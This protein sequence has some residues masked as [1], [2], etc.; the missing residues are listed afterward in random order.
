M[1]TFMSQVHRPIIVDWAQ[2]HPLPPVAIVSDFFL[3][4]THQ[5]DSQLRIPRLVFSPSAAFAMSIAFTL[6]RDLPQV[7]DPENPN[8]LIS[9]PKIPTSPIYPWWQISH[10]YRENKRGDPDW[11]FHRQ[12]TLF[13]F[14]SWG[15]AFN[16]F[17]ELEPAYLDH[18][19]KDVG[20]DRVW[21]VGPL[22]PPKDDFTV[23][24]ADRGGSSSVPCHQL[25]TWLDSRT[26]SS[27]LYVCFGSRTFLTSKQVE[28]LTSALELSGI[29]FILSVR[30]PDEKKGGRDC[31]MIPDDFED[32]VAGRG[33]VIKGWAP[34]LAI[35]GHPAVGAFLTHCG[36][37]SVLEGLAAGV[38][39]GTW[40]MGSDQFTNAK[41]LVDQLGVAIRVAEGT[42]NVPEA[43]EM[44]R[45]IESSLD[46]ARPERIRAKELMDAALGAISQR[47][48]SENQMEAL[49]NRLSQ[50]K[51]AKPT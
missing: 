34:Q 18:V 3:G 14:A 30:I 40:P 10:Q 27:V 33:L 16:S 4:W 1:V 12:N 17:T 42:E 39:M 31:G 24:T 32:R 13:N 7:D 44:A 2:S 37:N 25:L 45:K 41:L 21:A 51:N 6:W 19:K 46:K 9:F 48:S 28:I 8:S 36:W 15:F 11:E 49:V 50:L 22:L 43:E 47:G 23:P 38:V 20:H 29:H 35:L 26:D 5:L